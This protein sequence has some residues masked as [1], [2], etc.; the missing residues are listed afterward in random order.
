MVGSRIRISDDA[1]T[2]GA[3][4]RA[5]A[6]RDAVAR[7]DADHEV[8][9]ETLAVFR[10]HAADAECLETRLG[11][12]HADQATPVLRH[13]IDRLGGDLFGGHDEVAF[14]LAVLVVG[15]NDDASLANI[16]QARL[17]QIEMDRLSRGSVTHDSAGRIPAT[18]TEGK[19][20]ACYSS[21]SSKRTPFTCR[22]TIQKR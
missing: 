1:N 10:D 22:S 2:A 17:N 6:R 8:G 13:E 9:F 14:V 15:D 5:D 11:R 4:M 12:G 3:V 16:F 7:I 20:W 18:V 19:C 21:A